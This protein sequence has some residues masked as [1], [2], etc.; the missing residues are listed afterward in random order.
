MSLNSDNDFTWWTGSYSYWELAK[1]D[2]K[3]T[4]CS[5]W[6]MVGK[7]LNRLTC[8]AGLVLRRPGAG[9]MPVGMVNGECL[10]FVNCL[11]DFALSRP[12]VDEV[13]IGMVAWEKASFCL[14]VVQVLC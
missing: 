3:S 12:G 13:V 1:T 9:E 6:Q 14:P 5:P 8:F 2:F 4:L 7:R 10:I 11:P